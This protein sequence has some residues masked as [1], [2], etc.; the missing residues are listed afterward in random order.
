MKTVEEVVDEIMDVI[1]RHRF[2]L[3]AAG[4]IP[5]EEQPEHI[6]SAVRRLDALILEQAREH[7]EKLNG[8]YRGHR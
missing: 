8:R 2:D 1:D 6:Q 7:E 3:A 4:Y 5:L